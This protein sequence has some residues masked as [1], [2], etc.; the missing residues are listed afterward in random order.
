MNSSTDYNHTFHA[1]SGY[2]MGMALG[3]LILIMTILIV[4]YFC[5]SGVQEPAPSYPV[6]NQGSSIASQGSVVIDIGLNEATLASYYKLLYSQ[7][8]LQHKGSILHVR[9]AGNRWRPLLSL[10]PPAEVASLAVSRLL[11]KVRSIL[12]VRC[13]CQKRASC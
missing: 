5:S 11:V 1:T 6:T 2:A 3:I 9:C 13:I 7:A 8:K 12:H 10:N 4:A